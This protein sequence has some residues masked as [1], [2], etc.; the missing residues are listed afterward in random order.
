VELAAVRDFHFL[1]KAL[2]LLDLF[3]RN[4][5]L[6]GACTPGISHVTYQIIIY[7]TELFF[8]GHAVIGTTFNDLLCYSI[9]FCICCIDYL[10]VGIYSESEK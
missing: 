2:G 1:P 7:G 4:L 3:L 8:L 6:S 9:G 10:R 5:D